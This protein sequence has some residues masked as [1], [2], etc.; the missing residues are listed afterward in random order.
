MPQRP[1]GR[2]HGHIAEVRAAKRGPRG[3]FVALD[4]SGETLFHLFSVPS[5]SCQP[6]VPADATVFARRVPIPLFGAGLVEAIPDESL[7]ALEDPVDRNRDGVSGRAAIVIDRRDRRTAR[8]TIRM[9]GAARDAARVQR[10]RLSQRDGH[11]QRSLPAGARR[12]ASRAIA[13]ASAICIPDP[14][15]KRDPRTG[16]RG[17]D[18]F[19]SFMKFLAPVARGPIDESAQAGEQRVRRNR[20]RRMPHAVAANRAERRIRC[21]ITAQVPLFSDLLLHDVGTGDGIAQA[22]A[23]PEEI[24]TPALWGF[25]SDG[26]SCTTDLRRR[27]RTRSVV[28]GTRRNCRGGDTNARPTAIA[29]RCSRSSGLSRMESKQKLLSKRVFVQRLARQGLVALILVL[30][31]LALG[32]VGFHVL[33]GQLW[34]DALLNS[35]M[36]LGGM[37]PVGNLGPSSGK[38]FAAFFALYSGLVFLIVAGLL[39]MPVFHLVLH[40]FHLDV[41]RAEKS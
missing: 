10:R 11:H 37:G 32:T 29:P 19:A 1:G 14:E 30:G 40:R 38:L 20:L 16:R 12:R 33:S 36:L 8:R 41:T 25:A 3:E 13:C 6:Q 34:I 23:A 5:H 2:R 24:R 22:S 31:S 7:L 15:D 9:E 39:F 17:I 26:P 18:N 4:P 35:A 21:S 28:T 27:S